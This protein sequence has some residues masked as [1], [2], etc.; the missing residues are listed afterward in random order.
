MPVRSRRGRPRRTGAVTAVVATCLLVGLVLGVYA[1]YLGTVGGIHRINI[2]GLGTQPRAYNSAENILLI[3]A[4]NDAKDYPSRT[5]HPSADNGA[6]T[7]IL[8]H[9][10][11]HHRNA[12]LVSFPRDTMVP[13][14]ACPRS[15][16]YSGQAA[17]AGSLEPLN[18]TYSQGGPGCTWKTLEQQT[19]I[20]I[21]HFV[22]LDYVGFEKFVQAVGGAEVCLPYPVNIPNDGLHLTAGRHHIDALQALRFVR[23]RDI[24]QWSDLQ[25]I[26][27]QQFFMISVMQSA[28]RQGLLGDPIKLLS[29]AHAVA[30]Y[31]TTDSGF[32]LTA[33][34]SLARGLQGI[35]L[36][37]VAL[38]Q[39]PVVP[40]P[41]D[42][43]RVEWRDPQA[44]DLFTAIVHDRGIAGSGGRRPARHP[45]SHR[46]VDVRVLN[47][48]GTTGVAAQTATALT[49]AG[50]TVTGV[51]N[52]A[53]FGYS[54]T[55][56]EYG[57]AAGLR[58][59]STLA[60]MVPGARLARAAAVP[61]GSVTLIIG[62]SFHGVARGSAGPRSSAGGHASPGGLARSYSGVTA[63]QNICRDGSAFAG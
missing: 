25:R 57:A 37:S 10:A 47:G 49:K 5:Y 29:V 30:P 58:A 27:R 61:P 11:P 23:A 12:V 39:A 13:T 21:S 7:F 53:S 56:I 44:S 46:A 42:T 24:G 8:V 34:Y 19:G 60:R 45:L 36:P 63:N 15:G 14:Y 50:F 18:S 40:Y 17:A 33:M 16:H 1:A 59:A 2:A 41:P 54:A 51:G 22:Q 62:S 6:D 26:Q 43:N 20:R 4:Y 35:K 55:V 9:I 38:I 31:L 48:D 32:G 3:G 52:A 28:L